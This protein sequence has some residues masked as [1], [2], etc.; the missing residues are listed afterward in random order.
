MMLGAVLGEL[1][2]IEDQAVLGAVLE[3]VPVGRSVSWCGSRARPCPASWCGSRTRPCSSWRP[4]VGELV[5][6]GARA[7]LGE[8]AVLVTGCCA[9]AGGRVERL[10]ARRGP[11]GSWP[12]Q[13]RH[14]SYHRFDTA[15]ATA[16]A[17]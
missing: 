4:A 12:H 14:M 16:N 2:R 5:S 17:A 15:G 11:P 1:A 9:R 13:L 6:V 7:M 8:L 3:L 10:G